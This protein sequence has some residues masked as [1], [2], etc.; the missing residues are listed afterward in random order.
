MAGGPPPDYEAL[1]DAAAEVAPGSDGVMFL[2]WLRG[3][4]TPVDDAT[5]RAAFL[6]LHATHTTAA[7]TRAVL[8]GV[9]LN[10]RWLLAAVEAFIGREM[11]VLR[12]LGGGAQS[13]LWCQIYADVLGRPIERVRDPVF[14]QLRGA[15]LMALVGLG[16]QSIHEAAARVQVDRRFEPSTTTSTLYDDRFGELTRLYRSLRRHHRRRT[17]GT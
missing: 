10:G 3:E 17:S 4:H 8:E 7:M 1:L 14:A 11:P 6:H 12:M 15:A 16:E 9:T 5:A 13:D 2:P